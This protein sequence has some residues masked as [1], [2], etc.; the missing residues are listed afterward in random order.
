[1]PCHV[2]DITECIVLMSRLR[3]APQSKKA[4]ID[5]HDPE[6]AEAHMENG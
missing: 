3:P 1:M 2:M 6:R 4:W 5:F